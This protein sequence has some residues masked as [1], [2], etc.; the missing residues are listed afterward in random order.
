MFGPKSDEVGGH[1]RR[2]HN[3]ELHDLY[4]S[5][6]IIPVIKNNGMGGA[7]RTCGGE[8]SCI[9]GF[10]YL[11]RKREEKR[12]FRRPGCRWED[13]IKMYLSRIGIGALTALISFRIRTGG[14]LL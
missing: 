3:E 12:P 8:Q 13:N 4:S 14:A 1:W 9:Q 7:C 5:P 10:S 6:N 11:A 2:L